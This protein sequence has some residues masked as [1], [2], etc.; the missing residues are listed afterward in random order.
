MLSSW[1]FS[2]VLKRASGGAIGGDGDSEGAGVGEGVGPVFDGDEARVVDAD[3]MRN[4]HGFV[5][6]LKF[7]QCLPSH[8]S[9]E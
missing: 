9:R 6:K 2:G 5:V 8:R 1:I 7:A 3:A 4:Q